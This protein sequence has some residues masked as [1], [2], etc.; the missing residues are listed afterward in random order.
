MKKAGEYC[1]IVVEKC[2][3]KKKKKKK[4]KK[5]YSRMIATE[6]VHRSSTGSPVSPRG[7]KKIAVDF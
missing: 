5:I 3:Q 6:T 7:K 1:K 4:K 2:K